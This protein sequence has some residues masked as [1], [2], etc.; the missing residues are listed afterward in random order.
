MPFW[1]CFL[2]S[3]GVSTFCAILAQLTYVPYV[4]K[5]L[6]NIPDNQLQIENTQDENVEISS[7]TEFSE[8]NQNIE[9]R[10]KSYKESIGHHI[11]NLQPI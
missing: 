9:L 5:Q 10:T 1:Q 6:N 4:K 11:Q 7:E 3:F 8:S 2:I